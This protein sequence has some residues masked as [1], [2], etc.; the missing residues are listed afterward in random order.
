M[1]TR[2]NIIITD[3]F[4]TRL[5]FYK[6][7]DGY[8]EGV[9]PVLEKFLN[10]LKTGKIRDNASQAGGWLILLGAIE[11]QTLNGDL[12]SEYGKEYTEERNKNI[13]DCIDK[14]NPKDWKCGAYELT[15]NLHEDIEH[16]YVIDLAEKTL[17]EIQ[18]FKEWEVK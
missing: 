2:A 3:R 6:H 9:M 10:L 5:Y 16:L 8:P 7:S 14:L 4:N 17:T 1:S 11:Y 15:D 12:F 18:N 13:G